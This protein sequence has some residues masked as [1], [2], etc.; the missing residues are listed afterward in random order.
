[1][2]G[3]R[4]ELGLGAGWFDARAHRLR[5]AVPAPRRALRATRGAARHHHGPVGHARR[6][7]VR[8]RRAALPIRGQPGPAQAGAATASAAHRRRGRRQADAAPGRHLSPTSSTCPSRR[9]PTPRPS[10]PGYGPRARTRGVTPGPCGCP[11]PRPSAAVPTMRRW[12]AAPPTSAAR[13]KICG[14]TAWPARRTRWWPGCRRSPA[15]ARSRSTSRCSTCDDLEHIEPPGRRGAPPG[16]LT[17]GA[18]LSPG[19][20]PAPR[21]A[22]RVARYA[23]SRPGQ[24]T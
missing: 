19:H 24:P 14:P 21:S 4:A 6:R 18:R 23:G 3:G 7:D 22:R 15:S 10:S 5:R 20:R 8:L 17:R 13:R 16:L 12:S 9:W 11:P 1:M 2:S